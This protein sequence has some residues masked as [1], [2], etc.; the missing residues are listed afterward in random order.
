MGREELS[1]DY[2]QIKFS[3]SQVLNQQEP[4][5]IYFGSLSDNKNGLTKIN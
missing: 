3:L 2:G 4:P 5:E 1:N